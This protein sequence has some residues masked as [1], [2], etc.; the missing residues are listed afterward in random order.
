MGARLGRAGSSGSKSRIKLDIHRRALASGLTLMAVRTRAAPTV[1]IEC[2]T[3][4]DRLNEP[5]SQAGVSHLVGET[6][7][8]GTARRSGDELAQLI[9]GLGGVLRTSRSGASIHTAASDVRK[10]ARILCEVVTRPAFPPAGVRRARALTEADIRSDLDDPKAVAG[11][12]FRALAYGDH[13]YARDVRGS[14]ETIQRLTPA[15]L[16]AFHVRWFSPRNTLVAAVGDVDPDQTLDLLARTFG[17]WRG[18]AAEPP[19]P[20]P[21]PLPAKRVAK[22]IRQARA[23]VQVYLGHR[24]IRR[25]DP[26]FYKLRVMDH[27]LGSGPGF[28]S[29]IARKLRDEQ[30]LCYAVGAGITGLA[31]REPGLFMAYIGTSPGQQHVA[32]EGFLEEMR[33]IRSEPPSEEELADVKAYLTGSFVWGLERNANL[34]SFLVAVERFGLGD[35]YVQ[36]YPDLIRAVTAEQVREAA[37]AHLDPERFYLVT[38]GP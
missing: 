38:L 24:G 12:A 28:T 13:P 22:H 17:S 15:R 7:D 21:P 16:R 29:R 25:T 32:I 4:V 19:R 30:G 23:Q 20:S 34:A 37:A 27:V 1:A 31:G 9:E 33:R 11:Q 3:D 35:D 5:P 36:T 6:L 26:D 14:L 18:E 10:A 2:H 8:E